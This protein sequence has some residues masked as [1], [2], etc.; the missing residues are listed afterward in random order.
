MWFVEHMFR[1]SREKFFG[2]FMFLLR[3]GALLP[4]F[5]VGYVKG[6]KRAVMALIC[7]QAVKELGLADQI[8]HS[9]RV[10]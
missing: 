7:L 2:L 1:L 6:W 8:P 3:G 5:S 10:S 9:V 4:Q